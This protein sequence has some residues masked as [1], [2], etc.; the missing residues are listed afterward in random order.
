[1]VLLAAGCG[2]SDPGQSADQIEKT[3]GDGQVVPAGSRLPNPLTVTVRSGEGTALQRVKIRWKTSSG[4][5]LSDSATLSDAR[6]RAQVDFTVGSS[7][8]AYA[9]VAQIG[10]NAD[11]TV[12]F[13][14]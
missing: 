11:R 13:T 10:T 5:V 9:V 12:T 2:G 4:G 7:A 14:A 3:A 1:M 6:G 8:T